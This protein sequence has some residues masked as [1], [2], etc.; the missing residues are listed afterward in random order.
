M[1]ATPNKTDHERPIEPTLTYTT[2]TGY[3]VQ[4]DPATDPSSFRY[5]ESNFGLIDQRYDTSD[6]ESSDQDTTQWQRFARKVSHLN[7]Q[8]GARTQ[9]KVLYLGRHGE[10]VH[11]VAEDYYGTAAWDDYWSK[12]DGNG[13]VTWADAHLTKTGVA[14]AQAAHVFWKTQISEEKTPV[15]ASYYTSPLHRCLDTAKITFGGLHLPSSRPFKPIVKELLREAI[16]IHTC[17]RRSSKTSIHEAF[18]SYTIEDGFAE[19]DQLWEA[20]VRE[21]D[22]EITA[23]M[24]RLLDDIFL[25]DENTY[26]SFSS[27]SAAIAGILRALGHREFRLN[28]GAV[29]PVLVRADASHGGPSGR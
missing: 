4:D 16:G 20:D 25:R 13:T 28:T 29:I 22:V 7:R 14:Q 21:T 10:G 19:V 6:S 26:I 23:R 8:S 2:L 24:H 15:P 1:P 18:P 12:Q 3:F 11:N 27:H 9:Y 5:N 17:D